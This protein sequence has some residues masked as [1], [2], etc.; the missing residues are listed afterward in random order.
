MTKY[1][2]PMKKHKQGKGKS[3]KGEKAEKWKT[4]KRESIIS[5]YHTQKHT[6]ISSSTFYWFRSPTISW[7]NH[8]RHLRI[9]KITR[10]TDISK[11]RESSMMAT[12]Q[13]DDIKNMLEC[14]LCLCHICEPVTISCGHSFCRC[15]LVKS[16]KRSKK[17]C[18]SCRAICHI[19]AESA[20]ESVMLKALAI[21]VA[22]EEYAN[23]LKE[24]VA[25]KQ[26]W[27]ALLPIFYYNDALFPGSRLELHL[28]ELRYRVMMKRVVDTTRTFAYVPNFTNF[29]A[30][31]G[32]VAMVAQL[33]E[34]DI[35]PDGRA[36]L[37]ALLTG[38]YLLTDHFVEEGTQGLH[39]CRL[40]PL[41]DEP[42]SEEEITATVQLLTDNTEKLDK[43][44][45][46]GQNL[47]KLEQRCGPVPPQARSVYTTPSTAANT[48]Q[49]LELLSLWLSSACPLSDR[50]KM[51]CLQS[52]STSMRLQSCVKS[53]SED[54]MSGYQL[55]PHG[56][57]RRH[58]TH[59]LQ[60]AFYLLLG[61]PDGAA[62]A[63]GTGP[64][65]GAGAARTAAGVG[66]GAGVGL[67]YRLVNART[68]AGVAV[69]LCL[70]AYHLPVFL[71]NLTSTA[72]RMRTAYRIEN[73]IPP[74][75]LLNKYG[76]INYF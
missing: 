2:D 50:E 23:R 11:F 4:R 25:E 69:L 10:R 1:N 55:T 18:P 67:M 45:L 19:A 5:L 31:V 59:S 68:V 42:M 26:T 54:K 15:C 46:T 40:S 39:Y 24:A 8:R 64:G 48:P 71:T 52:K 29:W 58:L 75:L 36:L 28:F 6:K 47:A 53:L 63:A 70:A 33:E 44:I 61:S 21:H 56:L 17:K 74:G 9:E 73:M 49:H 7:S 43:Y 22:P 13:E 60:D 65:A 3:Q 57:W 76:L 66:A 38:R 32:D 51:I 41:K 20:E 14:A 30:K 27:E 72:Y 12:E 62:A 34:V 35:L 16:L 37:Q